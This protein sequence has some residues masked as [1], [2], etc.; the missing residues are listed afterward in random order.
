METVGIKKLIDEN[1]TGKLINWSML[2]DNVSKII[3]V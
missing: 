1:K 2:Y 3:A